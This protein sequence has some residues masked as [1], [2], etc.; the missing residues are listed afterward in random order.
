MVAG[1]RRPRYNGAI[2]SRAA[3][4]E[5]LGYQALVDRPGQTTNVNVEASSMT[6]A[7]P[8]NRA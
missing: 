6:A 1:A 4:G 7:M 3:A 8:T 2:D 5:A